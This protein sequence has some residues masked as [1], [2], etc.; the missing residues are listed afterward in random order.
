MAW[1]GGD[2]YVSELERLWRF[3]GIDAIARRGS[4]EYP[5][6]KAELLIDSLPNAAQH[7]AKY[8][9][10]SPDGLLYMNIGAP[11]NVCEPG[12][13]Q[14]NATTPVF[15]YGSIVRF[16]LNNWSTPETVAYGTRNSVGFDWHPDTGDFYFTDNGRDDVGGSDASVTNNSPDDELNVV[17]A[18]GGFYGFPYCHTG[19]QGGMTVAPCAR[20]AGVGSPVVDP[21]F[22]DDQ[23]ALSCD[24]ELHREWLGHL[25]VLREA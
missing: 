21:Q 8:I 6:D 25:C 13:Y 7:G 1:H 5:Q 19:A 10:I 16:D 20:K 4:G 22:N 11:C 15:H 12:S 2:L 3:P 9:A 14:K 23:K 17:K 18:A 24:G